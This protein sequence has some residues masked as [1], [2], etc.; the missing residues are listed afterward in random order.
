MK[1]TNINLLFK[2]EREVRETMSKIMKDLNELKAQYDF[3]GSYKKINIT[4]YIITKKDT[5]YT[6]HPINSKTNCHKFDFDFQRKTPHALNEKD[7]EFIHQKGHSGKSITKEEDHLI[8]MQEKC[9]TLAVE[10]KNKI[11]NK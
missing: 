9:D 10:V 7:I 1:K 2:K 3:E 8:Y 5:V 11:L 4:P 6:L